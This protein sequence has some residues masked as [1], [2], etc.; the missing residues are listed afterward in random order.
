MRLH[1]SDP[2]ICPAGATKLD[3]LTFGMIGKQLG[4]SEANPRHP[5]STLKIKAA[6]CG[7]LVKFVIW[8]MQKYGGAIRFGH[9]MMAAGASMI[10][11]LQIMRDSG[12][13]MESYALVLMKRQAILHLRSC[14]LAGMHFL[15]KRHLLVRMIWRS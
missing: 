15:P 5:G 9:H 7:Y 10:S 8:E 14:K 11:I 6:E 1:A 2:L 12:P 4:Y 13:I 3:T